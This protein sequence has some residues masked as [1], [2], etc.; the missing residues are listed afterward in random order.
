MRFLHFTFKYSKLV[1]VVG[2][3]SLHLKFLFTTSM[4][5]QKQKN[6]LSVTTTKEKKARKSRQSQFKNKK[7]NVLPRY[8]N[9]ISK[10]IGINF[11]SFLD[12]KKI[13]AKIIKSVIKNDYPAIYLTH[14]SSLL[15]KVSAAN[16]RRKRLLIASP[17]AWQFSRKF[18]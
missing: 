15:C 10:F 17:H 1:F 13:R 8:W 14:L 12:G 6:S 18:P 4:K 11:G 16:E 7:Q 2:M 5:T 3:Y 9:E